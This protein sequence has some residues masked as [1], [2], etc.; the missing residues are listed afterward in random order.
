[1]KNKLVILIIFSLFILANYIVYNITAQN[2]TQRINVT[3]ENISKQL[4]T[5]YELQIYYQTIVADAAYE[6]TISTKGVIDIL[7]KVQTASQKEKELLR[8]KLYDLL[9]EKYTPLKLQGVLQYQFNLKDNTTFLRLHK[10][11]K[12]D[13]DLTNIRYS[14]TY[15]NKYHKT[16][17]GLEQGKTTHGFRNVYP[18]FD[19]NKN[20]LCAMEISYSSDLI[21]EMLTNVSK[22]HT[23]FIVNKKII[24]ARAWKSSDFVSTYKQSDEDENFMIAKVN[25]HTI[26]EHFN[27][28][29]EML[30]KYKKLISDTMKKDE[31]F[32]FFEPSDDISRVISFYPIKNIKDKKT[33]AWL[34]AYETNSFINETLSNTSYIRGLSLI[35][36]TF[37]SFFIYFN[38][39]QKEILKQKVKKKTK[40]LKHINTNLE[41][42][43]AKEVEKNKQTQQQLFKSEKLASMGEMIGNIAHQWRQPLSIISTT[44]TGMLVQKQYGELKDEE[45]IKNC[46][47]IDEKTQ[48]LSKTI[49]DFRNFIQGDKKS[50]LFNIQDTIKSFLHLVQ[51]SMT[52]HNIAV[53][54]ENNKDI[55]LK[56][57]PNEL[58]QC[59][60]NI[61]NNSRDVLKAQE[62]E[63]NYIFISVEET[64]ESIV[65]IFKDN[66]GGIPSKI[67]PKIFEPYFTTKHKSQGTGLGLHMTYNLIVNGMHGSIEATNITYK[68]ESNSYKGAQF[69]IK[70]PKSS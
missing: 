19:E 27:N 47:L 64:K 16:I 24:D 11:S 4:Q 63:K 41:K 40:E 69:K 13:D 35:L 2:Q 39:S 20:Y 28:Y 3:L 54:V 42:K 38:L 34:V 51:P 55:E 58:I 36:F 14:Y 66:G 21:Q 18:I 9:I 17:R 68:Y 7:K 32:S 33:V 67:L 65:I 59:F 53:I 48:Y 57:H 1:M 31:K 15:V 26:A 23:H 44:A 5:H 49:D 8:K 46:K 70:L 45:L 60:I 43:I 22:I 10:P 50:I 30:Q 56:N 52:N 62:L 37:L 61:Y 29:T 12:F 6:A 25:T